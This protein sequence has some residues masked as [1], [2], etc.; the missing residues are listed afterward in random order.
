MAEEVKHYQVNGKYRIVI[1]RSATAKG[2]LGYK[3]EAN[4]DHI[5][6]LLNDIEIL[7]VG[8]DKVAGLPVVEMKKE[9]K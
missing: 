2:T 6:E 7:K 4:A 5:P 9:D 1:E 3:I 8:A